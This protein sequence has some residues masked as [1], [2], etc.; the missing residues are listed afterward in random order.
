[1]TL[2]KT[3]HDHAAKSARA[4]KAPVPNQTQVNAGLWHWINGVA[5]GVGHF[6]GKWVGETFKVEGIWAKYDAD[7][8]RW[9]ADA[10][11]H[12]FS[13]L[14]QFVL[15]PI[16]SRLN[17]AIARLAAKLAADMRASSRAI[18][19]A[20][21]AAEAYALDLVRRETAERR[22]QVAQAE[23]KARQEIRHL[24][25]TI[26]REA[27]SG[28]ALE[29]QARTSLIIRL[30][31]ILGARNPVVQGLVSDIT[32]ALIDLLSVDDPIAR[33]TISFLIR[34]VIDKLG[35]EKPL[36]N[37]IDELLAPILGD[38]KPRDLHDVIADISQRLGVME[39]EWAQ[40]YADGGS[41]VEQAGNEWQAITGAVVSVALTAWVG[42]AVIDPAAWAG[43]IQAIIGRPANDLVSA[44]AALF[45]G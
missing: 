29:R 19:A 18:L 30:L 35:I 22:R 24:H 16:E 42:Q 31:E 4:I 2:L 45:R 27:A 26:E 9:Y 37:L 23:H 21:K 11:G 34:H 28:Y 12:A 8:W 25:H 15:S 39:S 3:N 1:M 14:H 20:T 44:A 41:Q 13:W 38:A 10:W 17:R 36:G 40:F 43:D 32:T 7:L 5:S 6:F 33:I